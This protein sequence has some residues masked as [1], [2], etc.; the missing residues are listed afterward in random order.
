MSNNSILRIDSDNPRRAIVTLGK[1]L[2]MKN[3][4][5]PSEEVTPSHQNEVMCMLDWKY[6]LLVTNRDPIGIRRIE[7]ED[8]SSPYSNLHIGYLFVSSR[9]CA[10]N[11]HGV[12]LRSTDSAIGQERRAC[13]SKERP[14]SQS[15]SLLLPVREQKWPIAHGRWNASSSSRLYF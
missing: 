3:K 10:T 4:L 15:L 11:H 8:F 2:G 12:S 9:C 1:G 5:P 14:I 6:L 7:R 13:I